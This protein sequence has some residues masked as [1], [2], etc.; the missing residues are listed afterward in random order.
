MQPTILNVFSYILVA[1]DT[2]NNRNL[3]NIS[4]LNGC[5]I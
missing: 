3:C 1:E 4:M 5:I 2:E